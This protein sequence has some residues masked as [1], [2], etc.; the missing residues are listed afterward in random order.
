MEINKAQSQV[1]LFA[2]KLEWDDTPCIDKF[3]HL[4]EELIEMSRHLRYKSVQE[5]M[6]FVKANKELF[7]NE[8]GDL[9]F[10]LCRLSNQLGVNLE[11]G[12]LQTQE[13]VEKKYTEKGK[14]T[15]KV[16]EGEPV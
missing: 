9:F 11:E 13:K 10:G 2:E 14:E 16:R 3:D 7:T 6:D 15:N 5:R 8:M 12:F 1:K 4:H